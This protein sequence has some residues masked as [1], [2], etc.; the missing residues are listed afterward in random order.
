MALWGKK[1]KVAD[2][3][4]F[5]DVNADG[6]ITQDAS[7]RKLVFLDE[8][9]SLAN[10]GK[11]SQGP[12][13]YLVLHTGSGETERVRL[14]KI[15]SISDAPPPSLGI[16]DLSVDS[17]ESD[18]TQ[19]FVYPSDASVFTDGAAGLPDPN[20][21][22]GWYFINNTAGKKINWYFYD[23]AAHDVKLSEFSA[24]A[25][26]TIDSLSND[27]APFVGLYTTR[28]N[29][30]SDAS[31]WYRSRIVY[32]ISGSFTPGT[33]YVL[34]TTSDPG[35]YPELPRIQLT[36]ATVAGINRGPRAGTER[37][38]TV[39][40]NTNS[41]APVNAVKLVAES[42]GVTSSTY[43]TNV[44]LRDDASESIESESGLD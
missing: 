34:Y 16:S 40:L 30:G 20:N 28:Q 5:L 41:T 33:K 13:W 19:E 12:G 8:A 6:S 1:D 35:V 3:P 14:E 2:R 22:D 38:M 11:G 9:E 26:V 29:D 43:K 23:G 32:V 7:G 39:A 17:E 42:V 31:S 18:F 15:V 44:E 21:R 10:A 36:P 37:V 24:Y 27:N 4:K 25:V